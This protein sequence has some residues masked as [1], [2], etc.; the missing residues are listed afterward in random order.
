M[1]TVKQIIDTIAR[2][3]AIDKF[4]FDH[5][6]DHIQDTPRP[7]DPPRTH[8]LTPLV[9]AHYPTTGPDGQTIMRSEPPGTAVLD[10]TNPDHPTVYFRPDDPKPDLLSDTPKPTTPE[11]T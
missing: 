7:S 2:Q 3:E 9:G 6:F 4:K 1:P 11:S 5:F 10:T 8:G